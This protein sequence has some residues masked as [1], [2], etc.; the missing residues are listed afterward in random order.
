MS[1]ESRL[2]SLPEG[3][4]EVPLRS[5]LERL[6]SGSRPHGGVRGIS[7]GVPS[8]G[9]EH[10]TNTGGFDFSSI[11]YVP[12]DFYSAMRRG[13]IRP[14]DV[15]VVKDGAT[16][17]KVSLVRSDFPFSHAVVN[18]HVFVC[19]PSAVIDPAFL[20]WFLWSELGQER[21]LENFQGSAQGGINQT[22]ADA[23]VVPLAPLSEQRRIVDT[24]EILLG[25]LSTCCDQLDRLPTILSRFRQAVL[26]AA[27][28]GR[29]TE[30]W[31][32]Q[33]QFDGTAAEDT[34][35]QGMAVI[36][37]S[38]TQE[39]P[40]IPET[41]RWI[42]FGTLAKSLRMG[43]TVPPTNEPTDYPVLRSSSVRPGHI[44]YED[45]RYLAA[46]ESR[47]EE[48]FIADGDLLFTRLS[49]SIEYVANCALVSE[50]GGRRMQYPD[51]VFRA[52]LVE[53]SLGGY[54]ERCFASP[55]LRAFLTVSSKSSAGH[56][57]ISMG[58]LT[59]FPVPLPPKE[60]QAVIVHRVDDLLRYA[61]GVEGHVTTGVHQVERLTQSVLARA[62]R[63]ELV[64]TEAELAAKEGRVYETA[65][66]LLDR[67]RETQ[68]G[69]K[70][71]S[72]TA[73]R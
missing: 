48:N 73:R 24:L 16:T 35:L 13:Q 58:A 59:E 29:L 8:L 28:S 40:E 64:P 52:R 71:R 66:G 61:D 32:A 20:H 69:R 25:K 36:K 62:F 41:W 17:G 10:L 33:R 55:P 31:R 60:E 21:V 49:G 27:C 18:E 5:V 39:L 46:H 53:P 9:G 4:T 56:Q 12:D 26:T 38:G 22:F 70:S 65:D 7:T 42:R 23:T 51:R 11:R 45:V 6:E 34:G 50:L 30:D 14:G 2:G 54:I 67:V 19:R 3:W 47:S 72:G 57:R 15:L 63:G 44:D 43:T 1:V 37:P 68:N